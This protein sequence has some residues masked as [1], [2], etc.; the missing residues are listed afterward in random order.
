MKLRTI[1]CVELNS[2][3]MGMHTADEMVKSAEVELVLA[4]PP[5]P[6]HACRRVGQHF[7]PVAEADPGRCRTGCS[8]LRRAWSRVR[9]RRT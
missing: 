7:L 3:A 6:G 4:R 8:P 5:C 9:V 1:G 2:I